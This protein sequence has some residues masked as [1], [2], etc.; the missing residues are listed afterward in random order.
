MIDNPVVLDRD[1]IEQDLCGGNQVIIQFTHP[2]FYYSSILE[3]V[4]KL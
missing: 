2:D 3:E 4:Y 1:Q